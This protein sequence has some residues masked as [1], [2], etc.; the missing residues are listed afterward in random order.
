LAVHN[1][2][3]ASTSAISTTLNAPN[4]TVSFTAGKT[5]AIT[6]YKVTDSFVGVNAIVMVTLVGLTVSNVTYATDIP[7]AGGSF[8]VEF[9]ASPGVTF[10]TNGGI[11]FVVINQQ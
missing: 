7:I 4:G 8:T 6:S 1:V 11:D 9:P 10:N 5:T 2:N 3:D